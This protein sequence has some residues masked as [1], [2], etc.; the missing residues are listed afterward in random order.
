MSNVINTTDEDFES[1]VLKSNK[2]VLVDFWAEW[3]GPC[4]AI[5][6]VLEMMAREHE[7]K[8]K[9]VKINIDQYPVT[10]VQYS[11]MSIPTLLVFKDGELVKTIVGGTSKAKLSNELKDYL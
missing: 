10:A 5:S 2:T 7:A 3:C 11:V 8:L 9:V 4:K 6:P 1:V